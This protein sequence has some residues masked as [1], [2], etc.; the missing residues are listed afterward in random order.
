MPKYKKKAQSGDLPSES[1]PRLG[2]KVSHI[3]NMSEFE[4]FRQFSD[5]IVRAT[6][7]RETAQY[8][9]QNDDISFTL[10]FEELD[11]ILGIVL[12]SGYH[13]LPSERMYWSR[14]DD[15]VIPIIGQVMS[16]NR[17]LKIKKNMHFANN[18][19]LQES[20][21]MA[22]VRPLVDGVNTKLQKYGTF[23]QKLSL[24]EQIIPFF[25]CH[26]LKY[27]SEENRCDLDTKH[28]C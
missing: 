4:V 5:E 1:L 27:L 26:S 7:I 23:C 22:K 24:D 12:L 14:S 28:G 11:N 15:L 21:T 13:R 20:D 9:S 3:I 8:T 18:N 10:S 17:F 16:R 19:E 25:G 2:E 6:I